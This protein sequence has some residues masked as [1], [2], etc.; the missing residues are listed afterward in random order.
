MA[1]SLLP[2]FGQEK[3]CGVTKVCELYLA[4]RSRGVS[5]TTAW[6]CNLLMFAIKPN[7]HRNPMLAAVF[8]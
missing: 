2:L 3:E 1:T 8:S 6:I 5:A 4:G 7:L